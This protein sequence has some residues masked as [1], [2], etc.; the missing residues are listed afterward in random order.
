M[1]K[2]SRG[3]NTFPMHSRN[4]PTLGYISL[5]LA[6]EHLRMFIDCCVLADQLH[7]RC[8][9]VFCLSLAVSSSSMKPSWQTRTAAPWHAASRGRLYQLAAHLSSGCQGDSVS[10]PPL[11]GARCW[12]GIRSIRWWVCQEY[13]CIWGLLASPFLPLVNIHTH[14]QFFF[15]GFRER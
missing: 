5:R 6:N 8:L 11:S 9:F 1:W 12:D 4:R 2:R 7:L 14:T 3:L 10:E 15:L 13:C